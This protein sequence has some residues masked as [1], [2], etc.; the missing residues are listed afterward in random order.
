MSEKNP[1][2]PFLTREEREAYDALQAQGY[3]LLG[4]AHALFLP[5]AY[6]DLAA[7]KKNKD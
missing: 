3:A 5:A 4:Q 1:Y 2:W 7:K 6:A